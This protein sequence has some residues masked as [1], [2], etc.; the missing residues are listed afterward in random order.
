[1]LVDISARKSLE[2]QGATKSEMQ[3]VGSIDGGRWRMIHNRL[4]AIRL[5]TDEL[6]SGIHCG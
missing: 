2:E 3:A 5:N 4:T 1:M 6:L